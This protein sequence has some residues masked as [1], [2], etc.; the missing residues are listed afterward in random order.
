MPSA[1]YANVL[2]FHQLRLQL[3]SLLLAT[4]RAMHLYRRFYQDSVG[5]RVV[6]LQLRN[7]RSLNL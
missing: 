5:V 3:Y 6:E 1:G 4:V 2:L 7:L